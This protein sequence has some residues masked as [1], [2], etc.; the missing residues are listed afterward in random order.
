MCDAVLE[1]VAGEIANTVIRTKT[2][3]VPMLENV[4]VQKQCMYACFWRSGVPWARN[5]I[6]KD[7]LG[8]WGAMT[9]RRRPLVGSGSGGDGS[10]K[11]ATILESIIFCYSCCNDRFLLGQG[12][13]RKNIVISVWEV[14]RANHVRQPVFCSFFALLYVFVCGCFSGSRLTFCLNR[15]VVGGDSNFSQEVCCAAPIR[16]LA[17]L[18]FFF[19]VRVSCFFF[20]WLFRKKCWDFGCT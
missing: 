11:R 9:A 7:V 20:L 18:F 17:T 3:P 19:S 12:E 6:G 8:V 1:Y 10:A 4:N 15:N 2:K 5:P 16:L 13:L 14:S